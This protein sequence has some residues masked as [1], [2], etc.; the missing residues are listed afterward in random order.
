MAK[1]LL[2]LF[3]IDRLRNWWAC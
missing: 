3:F 2:N 1:A